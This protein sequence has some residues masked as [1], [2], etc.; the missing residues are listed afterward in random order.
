[1]ACDTLVMQCCH[2]MPVG[3][4]MM[5]GHS[6]GRV[7]EILQKYDH[8]LSNLLVQSI[9]QLVSLLCRREI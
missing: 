4:C 3:F 5:V 1:M 8:F 7:D 9:V 6:G 2:T